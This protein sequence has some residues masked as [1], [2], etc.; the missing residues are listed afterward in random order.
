MYVCIYLS[1]YLP[2]YH[3]T[4]LSGRA[5]TIIQ[6][7]VQTHKD[8]EGLGANEGLFFAWHERSF[9]GAWSRL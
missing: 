8:V 9:G 4:N 6:D 3:F 1:T 7:V 5:Q 2:T